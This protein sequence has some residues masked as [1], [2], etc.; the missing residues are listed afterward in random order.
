[1][2]GTDIFESYVACQIKILE[3][4]SKKKTQVTNPFVTISRQA[5]AGGITIGEKLVAYLWE[6]DKATKCPWAIFDKTLVSRVLEEHKFPGVF[7]EY[8]PESKVS[9][10]DDIMEELFGLHPSEWTLVQ[11]TSETILNLAQMG[12]VILVG[13]GSNIIT[14]KLDHG[15]HIR[16]IASPEKRVEHLQ[17]YYKLDKKKAVKFMEKEDKGRRDYAKEHFDKNIDDPLQYD[18]II[19]TD[20][21]SYDQAASLIAREVLEMRNKIER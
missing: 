10:V 1:M 8:M 19:N 6:N 20:Q 2:R 5:G 9:Q 12:N 17:E 13:R 16:L 3:D 11:K 7:S 4:S 15:F 18:L 14:R 21:I